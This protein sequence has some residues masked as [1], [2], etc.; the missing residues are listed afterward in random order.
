MQPAPCY[1]WCIH[2]IHIYFYRDLFIIC[3]AVDMAEFWAA[4]TRSSVHMYHL[5]EDTAYNRC[6]SFHTLSSYLLDFTELMVPLIIKSITFKENLRML[7]IF[8][9]QCWS[10][11]ADGCAVPLWSSPCLRNAWHLQLQRENA[12]L[13]DHELHGKL[14]KVWV[15]IFN[16][17]CCIF[18]RCYVMFFFYYYYYV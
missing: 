14:H 8:L 18:L 2:I 12:C 16:L 4:N 13:A 6:I 9:L 1:A 17:F 7:N 10:V 11:S 3:P 15:F 5:P